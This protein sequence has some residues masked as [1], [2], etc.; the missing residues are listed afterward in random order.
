MRDHVTRSSAL[1]VVMIAAAGGISLLGLNEYF[2][3]MPATRAAFEANP[4]AALAE[5]GLYL[6]PGSVERQLFV[7]RLYSHE[8][9]G[10]FGLANSLAGFLVAWLTVIA[11]IALA[12]RE[13]DP[14]RRRVWLAA[15]LTALPIG[16]C[17]VL[18]K[19]R[20]AYVALGVGIALLAV[21]V[22]GFRLHRL[23]FSGA[24]WPSSLC[25]CWWAC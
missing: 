4:E 16:I 14:R 21:G 22:S 6:P 18:T 2:H 5:G 11:G 13:A 25:R 24:R 8:P 23:K 1:I 9:A 10:S 7:Q 17:L 19:S 15:L 3:T 12:A 20:S